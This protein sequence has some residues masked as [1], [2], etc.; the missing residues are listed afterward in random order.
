[1][2]VALVGRLTEREAPGV[3]LARAAE[4]YS[5]ALV[6]RGEAGVG[7]TALLTGVEPET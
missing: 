7:K 4:G 6:L 3:L 1:M 2:D 5:G